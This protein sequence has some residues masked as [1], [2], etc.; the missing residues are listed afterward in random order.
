MILQRL[1][2]LAD[3]E[4]LL[5]DTAF[6]SKEIACRIDIDNEG[7]FLG[8]HDLRQRIERPAKGRLPAKTFLAGGKSLQVPVRPV[9]RDSAGK[10]KTTDP[11][12]AGKEKP[13]V[14]LADTIAR[15][16]PVDRLIDEDK[17]EKFASQRGTF[18]RFMCHCVEELKSD[19]LKAVARFAE[20]LAN[21]GH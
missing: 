1:Y 4:N 14:F 18:W 3:R 8:L 6:V 16:L 19:D 13:A 11:A 21:D 10:W 15:V 7:N 17:R 12:A 9:V 20:L 5:D 2:E